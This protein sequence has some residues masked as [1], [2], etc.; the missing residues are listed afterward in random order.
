M[1]QGCADSQQHVDIPD[2]IVGPGGLEHPATEPGAGESADLVRQHENAE[3]RGHVARAVQLGDQSDGRRYGRQV[4]KADDDR[5]TR[6]VGVVLGAARNASTAAAREAYR[7]DST[8]FMRQR[9]IAQPAKKLPNMLNKPTSD[10]DHAPTTAG[11]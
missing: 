8:D 1:D 5:K 7:I 10:S 4:G 11:N 3:Q 2:P 6:N 9:P